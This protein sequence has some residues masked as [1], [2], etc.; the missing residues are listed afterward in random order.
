TRQI[1]AGTGKMGVEGESA[2]AQPGVF[3]I[4]QRA[5]FFSV[6]A[7]IDTMNKRPLINTRDEPHAD[8]KRYR[9]FHVIVGDSN[10]SEWATALKVGTTA[11]VLD[12]IER[13][14]APRIEVAQPVHAMKSISRDQ[15]YAWI[16][17]LND[18]RK[19]SAID[20]QRLYLKA[21]VREH[22]GDLENAWLLGEWEKVLDDLEDDV[23]STADRVDWAAKKSLLSSFREEEKL[24]WS[25]P[26]LQAIDLEYHNIQA[27]RGLFHELQRRGSMRSL[28]TEKE[29]NDAI[30]SPPET[31][32]AWFRGQAVARF[33]HAIS[34]IQWDE[35][36][37]SD[38]RK[39]RLVKLPEPAGDD[40][41]EELNK[42]V[43]AENQFDDFI[44]ALATLG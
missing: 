43:N 20:V 23:A 38:G 30:F 41:L 13:G 28:V 19:I 9:R 15:N 18:G 25:D 33:K 4:S 2:A 12:L 14:A 27:D 37:F 24:E 22:E 35:I 34:S 31:T 17:E 1:F 32:R 16:I 6:V 40:R 11:L 8:A 5:D 26:W 21:A 7:S 3:Q 10:M 39:S 44:R 29:I 42:V 36:A